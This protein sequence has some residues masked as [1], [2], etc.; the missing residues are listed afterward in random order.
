[1]SSTSTTTTHKKSPRSA[2]KREKQPKVSQGSNA[3]LIKRVAEVAQ[4]K[5]NSQETALYEKA[6]F[7]LRPGT[8]Q[9]REHEHL[10]ATAAL[11]IEWNKSHRSE[12]MLVAQQAG[13]RFTLHVGKAQQGRPDGQ[14]ALTLRRMVEQ[15]QPELVKL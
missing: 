4:R 13:K 5:A 11:V 12:P 14:F 9:A 3:R 10:R 6:K 2:P 15:M 7:V 1:M 8:L